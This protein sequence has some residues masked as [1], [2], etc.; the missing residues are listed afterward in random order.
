MSFFDKIVAFVQMLLPF[1]KR[2]SASE[3]KE[4]SQLVMDQYGFLMTQL[5]KALKDYFTLSDRVKMLHEEVMG[6]RRQLSEVL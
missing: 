3:L 2:K 6:L 4:F 5:D 1:L